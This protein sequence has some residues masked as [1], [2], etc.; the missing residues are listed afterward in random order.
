[1]AI[2]SNGTVLARLAGGLYNQ[3][4]SNTL[5][6]EL[7]GGVR[8][9]A[10]VNTFAN[11]LYARDFASKADLQVAKT[12]LANL[13][14]SSIPGLDN[15]VSAQLTAAG[16][17]GKGAKVV[18]LLNDFSN[19]TSDLAYG[20]YAT[21]FNTK[22]AAAL[23]M[24][25]TSGSAGGDFD[26]AATA[27]AAAAAEAA[28]AAAAKAAAEAAA[29]AAT[30][31]AAEAAAAEA[32]AA[33]AAKAA[34]EAAAAAAPKVLTT[35][36]SETL[37]GTS[38]NE[39]FNGLV[40]ANT[41]KTTFNS[42]DV[43]TDNTTTD[44]DTFNLAIENDYTAGASVRNIENVVVTLDASTTGGTAGDLSVAVT[45][46]SGVKNYSFDVTRA[47]SGVTGLTVVDAEDGS[48]VTASSDFKTVNVEVETAGDDITIVAQAIGTAG[49]PT[50]V[51]TNDTTDAQDVTVTGLGHLKVVS[52]DS[53]GVL[54]ATAEKSLVVD[55]ELALVIKGTAKDGAAT[56]LHGEAAVI[57]DLNATSDISVTGSGAGSLNL[58]TP[59]T[60]TVGGTILSTTATLSSAGASSL[61]SADAL[62]YLD[63]SG[64]GGAA[65]YTLATSHNA[66]T[67]VAVSGAQ[68]VTLKVIAA[69]VDGITS[70]RLSV[71]DT[72]AGTFTLEVGTTAGSVDLRSGSLIDVLKLKIDNNA[73]TL[74]V[75]TGQTVTITTDQTNGGATEVTTIAVGSAALEATNTLAIKLDDAAR[76]SAAVDI[77]GGLTIVDAKTVTIDASI[78]T[79]VGGTA[80]RS[81][82]TKLDASDAK[83]NVTIN[84]GVNGI[85]LAGANTVGSTG[86][87]TITGSGAVSLG[88][89]TLTASSFD[90]S[91]V[92]GAV[93]GTGLKAET[94]PTIKTGSAA[95]TLTLADTNDTSLTLETG[96]GND[97]VTLAAVAFSDA[98]NAVSINMG[99]GTADTLV[100][101][102]GS[103]LSK[104]TG[105]SVSLSGVENITLQ[106]GS[107][108]SQEIQASLLSGATYAIK[109][110]VTSATGTLVVN[111]ASTDT[112]VDLSTLVLSDAVDT[113]VAA[114][115]AT[116]S[117]ASNTESIAITGGTKIR[118]SITGSSASD[119]LTG[120][121]L[122]DT[123]NYSTDALLFST[124]NVGYD[125]IVGGAGNADV[126]KFT[127]TATA[128][129]VVALDSWAKVSGVEQITT[130]AN[131]EAISITLG[132]TA[133]T[134]GITTVNLAGDT[135]ST[136]NNTINVAAYT[137]GATLTGSA[138][139]DS[140]TGGAGADVITGGAL[141]DV[142]SGGAGADTFAY[143]A[144]ADLLN[145]TTAILDSVTGGDAIDTIQFT[146]TD[147]SATVAIPDTNSW[148]R[149]TGVE[150]LKTSGSTTEAITIDLDST[151][152]TAGIS[153]VDLS[154]DTNVTG[155]N[156]IDV[157]ELGGAVTIVGGSGVETITGTAS[158][159]NI[160]GGR[161]ADVINGGDGNDTLVFESTAT[162]NGVDAIVWG[163]GSADDVFNFA[164]FLP[165]GAA[166]DVN[167][168]GTAGLGAFT[169]GSEDDVNIANKV[170]IYTTVAEADAEENILTVSELFAEIDGLTDAFALASGKAV[171]IAIGHDDTAGAVEY[172]ANV[173]F[174]DTTLDGISGLSVNDIVLVGTLGT[175]AA[176]AVST[177]IAFADTNFVFS[178]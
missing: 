95:D 128:V 8:T 170:A 151:A 119:T 12:L 143:A 158:N 157:N 123:F 62:S 5:Y 94:V 106:G 7:V 116:T 41:A 71:V 136:A 118:N 177:A 142:L 43:I 124:S 83:S 101:T 68:N 100:F 84:A 26:A 19:M 115:T 31:A 96:A 56:I 67:D 78:D 54:L 82:I 37:N 121:T 174:I 107:S 50:T 52:A 114:M 93:S 127:A 76:D 22:T 154:S 16:A 30:K 138:G 4:L 169:A 75:K 65:T 99:E 163:S 155:A 88:S 10:D 144:V 69:D 168:A 172:A 113:T 160:R 148:S 55:A 153:T 74:S 102:D 87:L 48:T 85:T 150:I 28:A 141:A 164:N 129:T 105:G 175:S 122:N 165:S 167:G 139:I 135:S 81:T 14:L 61:T 110:D 91:A 3:T 117:A 9:A 80:N 109:A 178:A 137:T 57:V 29:A 70:D 173:Y 146:V 79:T 77:T 42:G 133:E 111:V 159:D 20:S 162:I 44:S 90:A 112:V 145:S 6:L 51:T 89:A 166:I 49:T 72:G 103:K 46:M 104:T 36:D 58:V 17:A 2:S 147:A 15:W 73:E 149:V 21:A 32:A 23:A 34:A 11:D 140:I 64:N 18:S 156:V 161:G 176:A 60:I 120:G 25:Q 47:L 125:S 97:T 59:G 53:T 1:M 152:Y 24:S 40:S 66:L 39:T 35:A 134:A 108:E 27:A 132:A 130:A 38:A 63:L 33:A 13:G 45:N 98:A 92:T 126:L 131:T 171:V 86:T